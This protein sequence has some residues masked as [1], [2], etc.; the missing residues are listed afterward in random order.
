MIKAIIFDC[1]GLIVDTETPKYKAYVGIYEKY[2]LELPL[3]TYVKCVGSSFDDFHPLKHLQELLEQTIDIDH[4]TTCAN[5]TFNETMKT[6]ML[7][8]GVKDY[9]DRARKLG[10]KIGLASSSYRDWVVGYL[11]KYE[12]EDYF[13]QIYTRDCVS[14]IKPDPEIYLKTIEALGVNAN[15]TIVFE[16]SL[17]GLK[18]AKAAGAYCVVVPNDVT[19]SLTFLNYDLKI[20]TMEELSLDH[21]IKKVEEL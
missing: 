20:K 17:N 14:N 5:L 15:E 13:D 9:L 11:R 10:I 4:Y 16:D 3:E 1:D 8:P 2:G 19:N 18:A 7:R 6:E 21:V 12:I